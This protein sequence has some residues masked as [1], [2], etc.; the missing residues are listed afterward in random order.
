MSRVSAEDDKGHIFAV[1]VPR[2][3]NQLDVETARGRGGKETPEPLLD[4][5]VWREDKVLP[6]RVTSAW[7]Y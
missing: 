4:R 2:L 3:S 6:G 7:L 1:T 5:L